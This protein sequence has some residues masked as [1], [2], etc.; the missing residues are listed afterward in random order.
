[1]MPMAPMLP[2]LPRRFRWNLALAL[3]IAGGFG[4][5]SAAGETWTN[6]AGQAIEATLVSRDR[7]RAVFQRPDGT[8]FDLPLASLS[9]DSRRKAVAE[10]GGEPVPERLRSHW[11]VYARTAQRLEALRRAGKI[12]DDEAAR[13]RAIVRAQFEAACD[14]L[15]L[16][17]DQRARWIRLAENP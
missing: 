7:E 16:P 5:G 15:N 3:L 12:G 17:A 2:H 4:V 1:M 6:S 13:Q 11:G 9:E 10:T 14:E 8:T